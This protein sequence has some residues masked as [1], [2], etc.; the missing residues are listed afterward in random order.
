VKIL[1]GNASGQVTT[2]SQIPQQSAGQIAAAD[3]VG[4]QQEIECERF[5]SSS[6]VTER[7][8]LPWSPRPR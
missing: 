6:R 4:R 8:P 2:G 3:R 5:G 7:F 1:A